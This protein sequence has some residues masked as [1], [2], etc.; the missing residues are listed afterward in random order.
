MTLIA[1]ALHAIAPI[2]HVSSR[3]ISGEDDGLMRF[4]RKKRLGVAARNARLDGYQSAH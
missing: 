1:T 2:R 4:L 3:T